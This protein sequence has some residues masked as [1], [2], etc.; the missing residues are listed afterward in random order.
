MSKADVASVLSKITPDS[1]LMVNVVRSV[2]QTKSVGDI[3]SINGLANAITSMSAQNMLAVV[4]SLTS[5]QTAFISLVLSR[6]SDDT[7]VVGATKL[8]EVLKGLTSA[9]LQENM[10]T[11]IV[12]N[13]KV[14]ALDL[15]TVFSD[16]T[17]QVA[18]V[19]VKFPGD[20]AAQASL[21]SLGKPNNQGFHEAFTEML[22]TAATTSSKGFIS[23]LA[24]QMELDKEDGSQQNR[25][26]IRL[27]SGELYYIT[28]EMM[29]GMSQ[30]V[31]ESREG[32]TIAK[33]LGQ[34]E[35]GISN[36]SRWNSKPA[37]NLAN[38]LNGFGVDRE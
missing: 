27:S 22:G 12:L 21:I 32:Q 31:S 25:Y 24:S 11:G 29:Q 26:A 23:Q 20:A 33:T 38:L 28:P 30:S 15:V 18:E 6:N 35:N 36:G 2:F 37:L 13:S 14:P 3:A 1:P 9:S 16:Q 8:N 10:A 17:K 19:L 34:Y 5:N 4:N 7:L